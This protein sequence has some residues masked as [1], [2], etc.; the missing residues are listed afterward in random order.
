MT[1]QRSVP[2]SSIVEVDVHN[3]RQRSDE[4]ADRQLA[5]SIARHGVIQPL[6][7]TSDGNGCYRLVAGHRRFAAAA[8]AAVTEVPVVVRPP[9]EE[10]SLELTVVEN[11]LRED[12][13]PVSEALGIQRLMKSE[14]LNQGE[15]AERLSISPARV[16]ERLRLL[17][18]PEPVQEHVGSGVL[19]TSAAKVLLEIAKVSPAV[20]TAA[21]ELVAAEAFTPQ[22]L[23]ESPATVLERV[24]GLED[25][26][27]LAA[28]G[29]YHA[30]YDLEELPLSEEVAEELGARLERATAD[31]YYSPTGFVFDRDDVD[32][33][34][35][36]GCLIEIKEERYFARSFITDPEFIADRIRENV[37]GLEEQA[38]KR[39]ELDAKRAAERA[40]QGEEPGQG[41]E[42]DPAQGTPQDPEEARR[43]EREAEKESRT[44]AHA[45]NVRLGANL[46]EG[47][48]EVALTRELARLLGLIV[49]DEH[50]IGLAARGLRYVRE[51]WQEVE[52]RELKSGERRE[53]VLYLEPTQ[54]EE[55]LY[56]W[57]EAARTPEQMLGRIVQALV[58]AHCADDAA[59]AMSNR[60]HYELPGLY[61]GGA[62]RAI[63]ELVERLAESHLPVRLAEQLRERRERRKRWAVD[64]EDLASEDLEAVDPDESAAA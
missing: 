26:P 1:E 49:L 57:F 44:E 21:A 9:G 4:E 16:S 53:K 3:P 42:D 24:C 56:E 20:A 33:A 64:D 59:V 6:V 15:A 51:D 12:L 39:A 47:L 32:A 35:A 29:G 14:K 31:A 2:L 45:A 25:G 10:K 22:E 62:T 61:G 38:R 46:A 58:A 18:L 48:H 5:D 11:L 7:V 55:R 34:R 17:K 36:Y 54:A 60:S 63:P 23:E 30:A 13:D 27:V 37:E 43:R 28:A 8:A 40:T 50:A 52:A 19:P 41:E